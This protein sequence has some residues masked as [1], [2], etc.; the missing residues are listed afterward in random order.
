M[1]TSLTLHE[2]VATARGRRKA[3]GMSQDVLARRLGVSRKLIVDFEGETGA[4]SIGTVLR[5]MDVLGL[6]L[7]FVRD[8]PAGQS[9]AGQVDLDE[10]LEKHR[11][12]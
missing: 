4:S 6:S 5:L 3:L 10:L 1:A 7:E 11:R 8:S 9:Q 2:V 12:G